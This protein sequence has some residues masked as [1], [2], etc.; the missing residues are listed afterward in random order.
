MLESEGYLTLTQAMPGSDGRRLVYSV[1]V[2][3]AM[4]RVEGTIISDASGVP[5]ATSE[6][7]EFDG[8]LPSEILY[9][10]HEEDSVVLLEID[11]PE[12]SLGLD[13]RLWEMPTHDRAINMADE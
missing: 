11:G 4:K 2:N 1:I 13:P 7:K 6:I 9:V 3:K 5:L 10:W 12:I 8:G